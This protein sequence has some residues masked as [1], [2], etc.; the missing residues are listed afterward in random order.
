MYLRGDGT[1]ASEIQISI[2]YSLLAINIILTLSSVWTACLIMNFDVIGY[3][4]HMI[5]VKP[6]RKSTI[7]FGKYTGCVIIYTIL[8]LISSIIIYFFI[9]WKS[10]NVTYSK[11]IVNNVN[12]NIFVGRKSYYPHLKNI[13]EQIED[14]FK[15]QKQAALTDNDKLTA[16]EI[17]KIKRDIRYS[18]ISQ[19]GKVSAKSSKIFTFEKITRISSENIILQYKPFVG[20]ID[21]INMQINKKAKGVWY[22]KYY[23]SNS[24]PI[25]LKLNNREDLVSNTLYKINLP[26]KNYISPLNSITLK[27]ENM[28]NEQPIFFRLLNSPE[29]KIKYTGFLDNYIRCFLVSFIGLLLII[30]ISCSIGGIFSFPIAIFCIIAYLMFGAIGSFILS[31]SSGHRTNMTTETK[32]GYNLSNIILK[33]VTPIQ[34]FQFYG[35]LSNGKLIEYNFIKNIILNYVLVQLLAFMGLGIYIYSKKELGSII[36]K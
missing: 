2:K 34:K 11:D 33:G 10:N 3:Q 22:I 21:T 16:P 6:I 25:F 12:N 13:K 20:V 31:G 27:F 26:R 18:I 30:A 19:Q 36:K 7:W 29:L 28:D 32:I 4:V 14:E 24:T 8:L 23:K 9:I 35:Y 15:K 17:L 1:L 5:S